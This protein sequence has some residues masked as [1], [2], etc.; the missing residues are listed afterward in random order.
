M[1][2]PAMI[3]AAISAGA[4]LFTAL[5]F[6]SSAA[7]ATG[8]AAAGSVATGAA[9]TAAVTNA[10]ATAA[11]SLAASF[12]TG[13]MAGA[14]TRTA[15]ASG[16][17]GTA[18]TAGASAR[19]A[20]YAE[21]AA[22]AAAGEKAASSFASQFP[23]GPMAQAAKQTAV[24]TSYAGKATAPGQSAVQMAEKFNS[25]HQRLQSGWSQLSQAVS[26]A[27]RGTPPPNHSGSEAERLDRLKKSGNLLSEAQVARETGVAKPSQSQIVAH[28]ESREFEQW[29]AKAAKEAEAFAEKVQL[30]GNVVKYSTGALGALLL[31]PKIIERFG[32]GVLEQQRPYAQF[33]ATIART[34]AKLERAQVVQSIRI[35]GATGGST[36]ALGESLESFMTQAEPLLTASITAMNALA[37]GLV[38]IGTVISWMVTSSPMARAVIYLAKWYEGEPKPNKA[39]GVQARQFREQHIDHARNQ[40]P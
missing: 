7:A 31:V 39:P 34:F 8:T 12:P 32:R 1:P 27:T 23:T 9:G 20:H 2:L 18:N 24:G 19:A 38:N 35:A 33:S 28:S 25:M 26:Q 16:Y 5:G 37:T 3:G 13:A 36:K 14:A 30:A 6:G 22:R 17:A 11:G 40:R 15:M 29:Q 10:G 21:Q 4:E